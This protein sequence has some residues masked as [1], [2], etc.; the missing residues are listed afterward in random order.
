MSKWAQM[1]RHVGRC[2]TIS[3][4]DADCFQIG[5]FRAFL[6]SGGSG[7]HNLAAR[8][9]FGVPGF[10]VVRAWSGAGGTGAVLASITVPASAWNSEGSARY[11]YMWNSGVAG[12]SVGS[13]SAHMQVGAHSCP[14]LVSPYGVD[15]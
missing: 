14:E 9:H 11:D 15:V 5:Y 10:F 3:D 1:R 6:D 8:F 7:S 13:I 4:P 2:G 12:S